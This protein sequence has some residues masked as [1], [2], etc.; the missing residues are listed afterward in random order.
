MLAG[1]A[2]GSC[3][4][5]R[6]SPLCWRAGVLGRVARACVVGL[7]FR[8]GDEGMLGG[9]RD[10]DDDDEPAVPSQRAVD[11]DDDG[12]DSLDDEGKFDSDSSDS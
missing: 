2:L 5:E 12:P 7:W 4:V 8:Y 11:A 3:V 9:V 10:D 1:A 6:G